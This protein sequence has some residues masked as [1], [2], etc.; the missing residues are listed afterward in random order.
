MFQLIKA[1][2]DSSDFFGST[3][4]TVKTIMEAREKKVL[5]DRTS[6]S[7]AEC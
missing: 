5:V 4:L 3:F 1:I 2:S 6:D 7:D